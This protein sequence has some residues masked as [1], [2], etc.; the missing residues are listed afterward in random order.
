MSLHSPERSNIGH[1]F[2]WLRVA[3]GLLAVFWGLFF[4]G[5]IDL[6][7]FLQGRQFHDTI[8]LSTGWGLLFLFLLAGPLVV[9]CLGRGAASS[10][11]SVEIIAVA[12]ALVVTSALS[13]APRFLLPAL[14]AA[15]TAGVVIALG[16]TSARS[17]LRSWRW[18]PLPAAVLAIVVVP[19]AHYAWISASNAGT[20]IVT[21]DTVGLDHWPAQAALPIAALLIAAVAAG[22]PRGWRL[23]TWSVAVSGLWFAVVS[24]VEPDLVG[25]MNRAWSA[26]LAAWCV[27]F[28]VAVQLSAKPS[29]AGRRRLST[30]TDPGPAR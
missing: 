19:A 22:H 24:L 11:A 20:G 23:L 4:Y 29:A 21:D 2:P 1:R 5:L 26:A 6:L 9:L 3:A 13:T 14:G 28:V 18:S 10:A 8:L 30:A 7:A 16:A 15:V 17:T 27:L 25:S 12:L